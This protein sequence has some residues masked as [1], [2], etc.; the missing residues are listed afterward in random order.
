[1]HNIIFYP[2]RMGQKLKGVDKTP[3]ILYN[4]INGENKKMI[5]CRRRTDE[6]LKKLYDENIRIKGRKINIGG[7]HSMSIATVASSLMMY[8]NLK[9]IWIDA[10]ADINTR[11][12]STT[13]NMHGMPLGF[14]TK[15]D[16]RRFLFDWPILN[17][18]NILYIG[19]REKD[20]YEDVIIKN[21]GI[22][23]IKTS[24]INT[25]LEKSWG[26]IKKF[27][28][29]DPVHISFDVDAIDPKEIPCTGTKSYNGLKVEKI[30]EIMERLDGENIVNVDI[31][32][33]NLKLGDIEEET[34]SIYN[35]INIFEKYIN[36]KI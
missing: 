34:T 20:K 18:E 13:G 19:L 8:N 21:K 27:I 25:E 6:D 4:L 12:S 28:K 5:K 3:K 31:A 24:E 7:D 36:W 15:L 1:M 2:C 30:K 9:V 23:V 22:K 26:K 11:R 32:E 29:E 35:F 17:F 16:K 33:L 14:L 10:H